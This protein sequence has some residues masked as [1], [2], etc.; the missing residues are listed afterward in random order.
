MFTRASDGAIF[1]ML[2]R[3]KNISIKE[4]AKLADIPIQIIGK[5]TKLQKR[6]YP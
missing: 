5:N 2:L 1:D 4:L 6:Y 3:E